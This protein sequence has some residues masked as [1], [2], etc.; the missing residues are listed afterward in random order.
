M[1]F[2]VY[3]IRIY[4]SYLRESLPFSIKR[5]KNQNPERLK[6]N[7]WLKWWIECKY[8]VILTIENP[9]KRLWKDAQRWR[10]EKSRATIFRKLES[11][12]LSVTDLADFRKPYHKLAVGKAEK[13]LDLHII[14]ELPKAEGLVV[15][16]APRVEVMVGIHNRT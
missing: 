15:S 6:W 2:R 11:R 13:Q 7:S 16:V 5:W 12:W 3:S 10:I 1:L 8:L 4:W 9:L 14:S